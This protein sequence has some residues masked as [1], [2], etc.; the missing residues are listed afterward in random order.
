[1]VVLDSR[2][3]QIRRDDRSQ[4]AGL[5]P[6]DI[7]AEEA[8]IAALL[9]DDDSYARVL[10]IVR[11][12]DFF[13]EQN[14]WVY[15]ACLSLSERSESLTVPTVAHELD[16]EGH[17]EAVG[18]EPYL[19]EIAG[20]YFTAIG[21]EAH[22][23]I[24]ARDSMYRRLMQIA[25]QIAQLASAGGPDAARVIGESEALLLGLRTAESAGDF[26]RLRELLDGFLEVPAEEDE[27]DADVRSGFM[28]LDELLG[29]FKRVI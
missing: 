7:A 23:R 17:L 28:D 15:E 16:R 18:G 22:A 12:E 14:G 6:H 2:P 10:P 19:Q 25:G 13:R 3:A 5:P 9:L 20:K 21:V 4:Q 27:G 8:I 11:P 24:V 29:G 1:L 26:K